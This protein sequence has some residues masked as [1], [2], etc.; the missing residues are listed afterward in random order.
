MISVFT[1]GT[2]GP[3]ATAAAAAPPPQPVPVA[4]ASD[5]DKDEAL[6]QPS[7]KES[8]LQAQ[9]TLDSLQ[10]MPSATA[11]IGPGGKKRTILMKELYKCHRAAPDRKSQAAPTPVLKK[12]REGKKDAQCPYVEAWVIYEDEPEMVYI[13]PL[14]GHMGH[15]PGDRED[16][17]YLKIDPELEEEIEK[18]RTLRYCSF[19]RF[20]LMLRHFQFQRRYF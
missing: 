19:C 8:F 1:G 7:S 16:L 18:V 2:G 15:T 6:L 14:N 5:G 20:F 17:H 13:F 11:G 12:P 10:R 9:V 3:S 4:P